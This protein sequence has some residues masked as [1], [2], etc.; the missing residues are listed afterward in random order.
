MDPDL[1]H[2]A[3]A[4]LGD[5]AVTVDVT[6]RITSWNRAAHSLLGYSTEEAVGETLALIV[7][8]THRP[9]H[10]AGFRAAMQSGQLGHRG[11]PARVEAATADGRILPLAMSLGLIG[12]PHAPTGAVAVLRALDTPLEVFVAAEGPADPSPSS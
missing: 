3:L 7:P 8:A 4:D 2:E 11:R 10:V 1:F 9:R 5:A 6:G 12:E